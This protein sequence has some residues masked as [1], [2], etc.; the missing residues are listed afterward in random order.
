LRFTQRSI[1]TTAIYPDRCVADHPFQPEM[2]YL[3][4]SCEPEVSMTAYTQTTDHSRI[5]TGALLLR[6]GLGSMLIARA[7]GTVAA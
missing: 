3:I 7:T 2:T 6:L 4:N 5:E 1:N